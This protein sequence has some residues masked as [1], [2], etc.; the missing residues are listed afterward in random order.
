MALHLHRL[1]FPGAGVILGKLVSWMS[2]PCCLIGSPQQDP[3]C[4]VC[5][6][7][8]YCLVCC[9]C[10]QAAQHPG[11]EDKIAESRLSARWAYA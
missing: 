4:V 10:W 2:M 8:V 6:V 7:L 5:S 9:C 11:E 1:V 3:G